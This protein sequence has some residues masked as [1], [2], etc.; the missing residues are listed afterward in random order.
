MPASSDR[1]L[2]KGD[3]DGMNNAV[4]EDLGLT[5]VQYSS[6]VSHRPQQGGRNEAI[7]P[8]DGPLNLWNCEAPRLLW[9]CNG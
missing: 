5:C 6:A 8:F 9:R 4:N 3:H 2:L 7:P 1:R